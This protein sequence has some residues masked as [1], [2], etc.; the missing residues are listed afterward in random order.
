MTKYLTQ[1][2]I[3]I[4]FSPSHLNSLLYRGYWHGVV[5]VHARPVKEVVDVI[6]FLNE[7]ATLNCIRH[8]NIQLFMGASLDLRGGT[9]AI[10][11]G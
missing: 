4:L 5:Q 7:V 6:S 8:E 1:S 9:V 11:M 3:V 10:V 2:Y